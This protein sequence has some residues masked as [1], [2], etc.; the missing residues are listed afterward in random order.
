MLTRCQNCQILKPIARRLPKLEPNEIFSRSY[1]ISY[2]VI[3]L[4]KYYFS[5]LEITVIKF[6]RIYKDNRSLPNDADQ[7]TKYKTF[8]L[9]VDFI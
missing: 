6:R 4:V 2:E 5:L 9:G 8:K 1:I 3:L 7:K